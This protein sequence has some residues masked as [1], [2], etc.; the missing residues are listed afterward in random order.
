MNQS[1]FL[2]ELYELWGL[3]HLSSTRK[4]SMKT[5]PSMYRFKPWLVSKPRIQTRWIWVV[6]RGNT[7]NTIDFMTVVRRSTDLLLTYDLHC[8]HPPSMLLTIVGTVYS[9]VFLLVLVAHEIL[10]DFLIK[11]H[12]HPYYYSHW[13]TGTRFRGRWYSHVSSLDLMFVGLSHIFQDNKLCQVKTY[14][15]PQISHTPYRLGIK[16]YTLT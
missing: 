4:T 5:L 14:D 3:L 7:L 10:S 9:F 12:V 11:R 1:L 8:L 15:L 13:L 2:D 6:Q 16:R